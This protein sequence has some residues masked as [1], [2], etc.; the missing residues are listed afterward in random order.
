MATIEPLLKSYEQFVRLPW[1]TGLAG[2]QKV[3][4][5][6][7][8]EA[9]ERRLRARIGAFENASV[10]AGHGWHSC[11]LTDLF[12]R[13]MAAQEYRESY[14][15][16]PEDMEMALEDFFLHVVGV[17]RETLSAPGADE[18]TVVSIMGVASL[19]G[20]MRVSR[21]VDQVSGS[22]Q[23]RLLVFFPGEKEGN[24]F[25]LL[26]ARDGWNYLAIPISAS[27]G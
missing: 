14:F 23:G 24:N 1:Q 9:D 6:V 13:W 12:A 10:G 15:E 26:D 16:S 5:A 18:K 8:D 4:M 21:L 7:Y 11:D 27:K 17:V 22:I 25:R 2:A 3:W 20:L 19:F